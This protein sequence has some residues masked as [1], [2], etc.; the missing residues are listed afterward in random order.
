MTQSI[1]TVRARGRPLRVVHAVS[2]WAAMTHYCASMCPWEP[3][4]QPVTMTYQELSGRTYAVWRDA[5]GDVA[6]WQLAAPPPGRGWQIVG[7]VL[8]LLVMVIIGLI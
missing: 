7:V 5:S 1:Y 6:A 3:P 4:R 2:A 8:V